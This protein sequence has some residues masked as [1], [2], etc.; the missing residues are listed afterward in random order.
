MGDMGEIFN[1]MKDERRERR[2]TH[3][4]VCVRCVTKTPNRSPS[5]LLPAQRC[6]VDGYVDPRPRDWEP[7]TGDSNG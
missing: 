4:I 7:L 2:R 5:I 1:A 3:G 6:K